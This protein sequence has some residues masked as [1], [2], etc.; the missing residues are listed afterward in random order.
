MCMRCGGELKT[1]IGGGPSVGAAFED[2]RRSGSGLVANVKLRVCVGRSA[3]E[4]LV[5]WDGV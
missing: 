5:V 3:V 2:T 1:S 4:V